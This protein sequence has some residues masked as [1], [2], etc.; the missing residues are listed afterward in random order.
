M[1]RPRKSQY[2]KKEERTLYVL[3]SP[4]SKKFIVGKTLAPNVRSTYKDHYILSKYKTAGMVED[5]KSQGLKPCCFHLETLTCTEVEGYHRLVVWTRLF[6]ENGYE[7]IEQ[8][9]TLNY[10]M[11]LLPH[12]Q[13][14]FDELTSLNLNE[15]LTCSHCLFPNYGREMCVLKEEGV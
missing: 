8:G 4:I 7:P 6:I 9:N 15:M 11:D 10:A 12:N 13:K 3:K 1:P 5:L 14:L 2:T